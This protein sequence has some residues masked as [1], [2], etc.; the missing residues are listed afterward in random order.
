MVGLVALT[1]SILKSALTKAISGRFKG[2][3]KQPGI[4]KA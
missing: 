3:I 4:D 1:L 2:Q